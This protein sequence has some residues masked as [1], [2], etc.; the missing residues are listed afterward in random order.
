[1]PVGPPFPAIVGPPV[2]VIAWNV[3][4]VTLTRLLGLPRFARSALDRQIVLSLAHLLA[5]GLPLLILLLLNLAL[6]I[7]VLLKQ[8][9]L[10]LAFNVAL[11]Q[12]LLLDLL[13]LL[14]LGLTHLVLLVLDLPLLLALLL[15][16]LLLLLTLHATLLEEL[17]A[18]VTLS[19]FIGFASRRLIT[20]QSLGTDAH[21]QK[22][23]ARQLP[24]TGFHDFLTGRVST[25]L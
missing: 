8:L 20:G 13:L 22:A 16:D 10:L 2:T 11:L 17:L 25:S 3:T 12:L 24:D 14:A 5:L 4:V 15:V 19:A 23:Q 6:L 1:M 9:L 18:D 7:T 21:A